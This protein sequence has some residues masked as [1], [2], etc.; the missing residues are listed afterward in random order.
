M[1]QNIRLIERGDDPAHTRDIPVNDHE[2]VIGRA[3]DCNLR[4]RSEDVSR[5]HC[6]LRVTG[7]EVLLLDLGSSNGTYLNGQRVRSQSRLKSGDEI[8]IGPLR[9][10]VDLGDNE[11][12]LGGT[13]VDPLGATLKLPKTQPPQQPGTP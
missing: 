9:F 2:F 3:P 6:T 11:V 1:T 7:G 10:V 12:S 13:E 8:A 5:H 4:L